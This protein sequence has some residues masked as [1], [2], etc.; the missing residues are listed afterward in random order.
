MSVGAAENP[1]VLPQ[2]ADFN[3]QLP[4]PAAASITIA[5]AQHPALAPAVDS[6]PAG[7]TAPTTGNAPTQAPFSPSSAAA[8]AVAAAPVGPVVAPAVVPVPAPCNGQSPGPALAHDGTSVLA[9][10]V[11]NAI[12]TNEKS[13]KQYTVTLFITH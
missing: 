6:G 12:E 2:D 3:T 9:H 1:R 11:E 7:G 5:V 10:W 8:A 4:A 13:G